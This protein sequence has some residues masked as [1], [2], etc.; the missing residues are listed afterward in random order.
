MAFLSFIWNDKTNRRYL[1]IAVI[2]MIVQITIFKFLY[3]FAD[4]FS[5]SYSYLFAAYANLDINIWPIGYSKF[6]RFFDLFTH[7]DTSLVV[8]Q[9]LFLGFSSLCFF[10]TLLYFFRPGKNTVL[11]LFIFLFFNPL[12][13]YICN[14]VNSDPIFAALSILWMTQ[15]IWIIYRPVWWQV[16]TQ[17][18]LLYACFTVRN[19]AM[20]YPFITAFVFILSRYTVWLKVAGIAFGTCL[21]LWFVNNQQEAAY[22]LT[23]KRQFSLFTG[24][25]LANNAL[26]MYKQIEVDNSKLPTPESRS[27]DS[28]A[29]VYFSHTKPEFQQ[30]L[31]AYVANF[32]I[33]QPEAPLKQ[34]FDKHYDSQDQIES[35]R[36]WGKAS[37]VFEDFGK[38]LILHYPGAFSRYYLL[39]N[40]KNYFLPPLEKLEVYNLGSSHVSGIARHWFHYPSDQVRSVS[41]DVQGIILYIFTPFF[42]MVNAYF[43]LSLILFIVKKKYLALDKNTNIILVTI[44]L[45]LLANFAFSVFATINVLRYQFFP[46][47]ICFSISLL[48][49]EWVDKKVTTFQPYP[50]V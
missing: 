33:R 12:F 2:G 43:L 15:L 18:V 16:L 46:M 19:N 8:F 9:Y 10:Y 20:Y 42:L 5:D 1:L 45:F 37:I 28:L 50:A 39:T 23:G 27:L 36:D 38:Y 7:S 31:A 30:G 3:P 47:I 29:K 44:T 11:A 41:K 6:L 25:I 32:F 35:I 22:K 14:Y 48:L 34:Y 13:L 26:Y 21:I 49:I 24:W 40:T 4:F 17:G